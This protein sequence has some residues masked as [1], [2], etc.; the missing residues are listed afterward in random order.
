MHG[1]FD[2]FSKQAAISCYMCCFFC[3][4]CVVDSMCKGFLI[5]FAD[6]PPS[7]RMFTWRHGMY[8]LAASQLGGCMVVEFQFQN[9]LVHVGGEAAVVDGTRN[10]SATSI[11]C[12]KE[13]VANSFTLTLK[14]RLPHSQ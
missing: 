7:Q 3:V 8:V 13:S 12:T 4:F 1:F 10:L 6:R 2:G 5:G 11:V 14:H 9:I